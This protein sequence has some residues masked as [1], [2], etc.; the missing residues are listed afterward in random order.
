MPRRLLPK[1]A[2]WAKLPKKLARDLMSAQR[3][4]LSGEYREMIE[5]YYRVIAE[6]AKQKTP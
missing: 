1:A 2:D 6:K 3:E 4:N 5:A